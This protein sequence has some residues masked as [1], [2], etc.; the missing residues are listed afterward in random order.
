LV[1]R[2]INVSSTFLSLLGLSFFVTLCA[3]LRI[4]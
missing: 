1:F 2:V 4:F 3:I